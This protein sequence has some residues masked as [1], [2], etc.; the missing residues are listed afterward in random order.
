[1]KI[2]MKYLSN[3]AA[4]ARTRQSYFNVS[5][6]NTRFPVFQSPRSGVSEHEPESPGDSG[7]D[8]RH[9]SHTEMRNKD[10]SDDQSDTEH[11]DQKMPMIGIRS[12]LLPM[13]PVPREGLKDV[14]SLHGLPALEALRRQAGGQNPFLSGM[15]QGSPISLP[16]FQ[17]STTNQRPS[18]PPT[19]QSTGSNELGG[20][21]TFEEQFKQVRYYGAVTKIDYL[22][23]ICKMSLTQYLRAEFLM[24]IRIK[25]ISHFV[26]VLCSWPGAI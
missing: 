19:P 21:W 26:F 15:S 12:D 9:D 4:Y 16:N 1:M 17:P 18:Q 10:T 14:S 5:V 23:V 7:T 13:H 2:K 24:Q 8:L 11:D 3:Y 20:S 22:V 25:I 6:F